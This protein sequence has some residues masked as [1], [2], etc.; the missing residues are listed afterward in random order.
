MGKPLSCLNGV[1][2]IA[3]PTALPYE[4]LLPDGTYRCLECGA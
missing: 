2:Q 3:E 1:H 4:A